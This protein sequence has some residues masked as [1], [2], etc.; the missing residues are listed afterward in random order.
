M[1]VCMFKRPLNPLAV[2]LSLSALFFVLFLVVSSFLL[3][4]SPGKGSSA[5]SKAFF[6]DQVIGVIELDGV[7][8]DSKKILKKLERFEEDETIKGVVLRI[9]SPGGSVAPSQEIYEVVKKYKKPLVASI[10][11]LGAS[12]AYYI[13]C[14][15]KKIFASPGTLT[16]SIGVI[17]EFVDLEKLYEW[18]K[19]KRYSIKTGKF[20]EI[21][22]E[23]KAMT[24]EERTLMQTMVDD[25]LV[26]FKRAVQEGRK[27]T[28]EQVSLI[29]DGRVFTGNQAKKAHLIDEFGGLNEAIA[30]VG[31]M[32]GIKG[33]PRVVYPARHKKKLLDL[34]W[35]DSDGEEG[36]EPQGHLFKHF[37]NKILGET[38]GFSPSLQGGL[39]FLWGS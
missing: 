25:V 10:G 3:F 28:A 18:A 30:E 29:S 26:Q 11:G 39:Y 19:V 15:A 16:G 4:R 22:A 36:Y 17:M 33:K 37:L 21:G 34:L 23:Y 32:A 20:K 14:G 5:V 2:I 24:T 6:S 7:I 8:L 13:A 27:M 1:I 9:N 38:A 31:K 35:D 12:G